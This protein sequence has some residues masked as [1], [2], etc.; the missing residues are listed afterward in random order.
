MIV[1]YTLGHTLFLFRIVSHLF[2]RIIV[3]VLRL[4]FALHR[5][6][7][8]EYVLLRE[9]VH[10]SVGALTYIYQNSLATEE[11]GAI[12]ARTVKTASF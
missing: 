4:G 5:F 12:G 6:P 2:K 7:M 11:C 3:H 10:A 1:K 8:L 9:V